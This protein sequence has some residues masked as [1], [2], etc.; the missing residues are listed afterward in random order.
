MTGGLVGGLTERSLSG[1]GCVPTQELELE[2]L[3]DVRRAAER[4]RQHGAETERQRRA[5]ERERE[6]F[7]RQ[8]RRWT[9]RDERSISWGPKDR[10]P[11]FGVYTVAPDVKDLMDRPRGE[12]ETGRQVRRRHRYDGSHRQRGYRV[13]KHQRYD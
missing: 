11:L 13:A 10:K 3:V 2:G 7:S 6:A 1:A 8:G 9:A 12:E 5:D 4:R